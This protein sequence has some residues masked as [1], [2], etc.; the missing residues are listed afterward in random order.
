MYYRLSYIST[1]DSPV[2]PGET[3][4]ELLPNLSIDK[5]DVANNFRFTINNHFGT[6]MD[7]PKHFNNEGLPITALPLESFI[8]ESPQ[9]IDVP[10]GEKEFITA[11]D[12]KT[13]AEKIK[14]ADLLLIRTGF[15]KI[16][17]TNPDRYAGKG[18]AVGVDSAQYLIENFPSL[19]A[20]ALDI[21]SVGTYDFPKEAEKAHQYLLGKFT[22]KFIC[23]IED[24]CFE[25]I[26]GKH[27]KRVIAS[28]ILV[29]GLDSAPVMVIAET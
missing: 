12:L 19:K 16:R 6:H 18:P 9:L 8:F 11:D 5:G 2:F 29:Q 7:A 28:P 17:I 1:L 21:I 20:I 26:A 3:K 25:E 10:K 4:Y 23:I 22:E 27:L 14:S 15:A 13:H 24:A